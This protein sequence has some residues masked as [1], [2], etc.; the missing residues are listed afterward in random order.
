M[1]KSAFAGW[2]GSGGGCHKFISKHPVVCVLFGNLFQFVSTCESFFFYFFFLSPFAFYTPW[3]GV[4]MKNHS[5]KLKETLWLWV[6]ICLF[7]MLS[8]NCLTPSV[9]EGTVYIAVIIIK[10]QMDCNAL[11]TPYFNINMSVHWS[12]EGTLEVMQIWAI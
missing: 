3:L 1:K 4:S 6:N 8:Q 9:G 2:E 12:D 10:I 7:A 11:T 5:V